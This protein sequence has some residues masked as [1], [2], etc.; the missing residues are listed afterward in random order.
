MLTNFG[1]SKNEAKAYI[2]LLKHGPQTASDLAYK[3]S[4]PRAKIYSTINRLVKKELAMIISSKPIIVDAHEPEYAF[5]RFLLQYENIL[6]DLKVM[7]SS[8]DAI[9]VSSMVEKRYK[10]V[11]M[12]DPF[13]DKVILDARESI[14]IIADKH[15]INMIHEM[16]ASINAKVRILI[17]DQYDLASNG[18]VEV[19]ISDLSMINLI[20]IDNRWLI[21]IDTNLDRCYM[22]DDK[23]LV[24]MYLKI[25]NDQ[26]DSC[27]INTLSQEQL[28]QRS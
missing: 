5:K 18:K 21:I 22:F 16:L 11:D 6:K 2:I 1:L 19:R 12:N 13:I 14:D 3:A 28:R 26:W 10:V 24:N 8:L 15:V 4:I 7:I 25:F 23:P 17:N 20:M 27:S 9:R